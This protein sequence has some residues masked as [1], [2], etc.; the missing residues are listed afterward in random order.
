MTPRDRA[1][2]CSRATKSVYAAR[3]TG[4][5]QLRVIGVGS[6]AAFFI[7]VSEPIQVLAVF[8]AAGDKYPHQN[9]LWMRSSRGPGYVMPGR[10]LAGTFTVPIPSR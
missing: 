6:V 3:A 9:P 8:H 4:G 5:V 7:V 1:R 10:I 2:V